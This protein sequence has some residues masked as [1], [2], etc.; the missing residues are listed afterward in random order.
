M[1]A[2]P[3]ATNEA[4]A[5]LPTVR[6]V[7]VQRL[8]GGCIEDTTD[9]V[10]E[11]RPV[12]LL[13]QGVPHVVMLASPAD[14]EDL[15]VGFTLSEG[16]A[17]DPSD[18]YSVSVAARDDSLTV[19]LGISTKSFTALLRQRRNLAGRTG[20]GLCGVE[21]VDDAVRTPSHVGEGIR[22]TS[23]EL[24]AQL[25]A[26]QALQPVNAKTGSVHAAA[27]VLPGKGIEVVREDVGRHNALDKTIGALA[28]AKRNLSDGYFIITSRASFEMVQKAAM[29][30]VSFVAAV[31]APTALAIDMA[32]QTGVTLVGFARTDRHVV[33]SHPERLQG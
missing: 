12:G 2:K 20:C 28:R 15:G 17:E 32:R 30:G 23:E 7:A 6:E 29:V 33:Y 27:W 14:L 4:A 22:V 13:Y 16:I 9:F 31:S 8:D 18:I 21:N 1:S 19:D 26:L 5:S 25:A 24:H 3:E 10:A 11:E